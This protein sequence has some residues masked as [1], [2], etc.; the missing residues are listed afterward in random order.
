[1][2]DRKYT[3]QV[4]IDASQAQQQAA[5]L[6]ALFAKELGEVLGGTQGSSQS[7]GQQMAADLQKAAKPLEEI[8][9]EM[10]DLEKINA[11]APIEQLLSELGTLDRV[12]ADTRQRLED[13]FNPAFAGKTKKE[14][15]DFKDYV[16]RVRQVAGEEAAQTRLRTGRYLNQK[17]RYAE[18]PT[19]TLGPYLE[20]EK[21]YFN[22]Q[23]DA[24]S[25]KQQSLDAKLEGAK[26]EA[27]LAETEYQINKRQQEITQRQI[28]DLNERLGA[29]QGPVDLAVFEQMEMAEQQ[30]RELGAQEAQLL[31]DIAGANARIIDITQQQQTRI[32][33]E[34]DKAARR[35]GD[36]TAGANATTQNLRTEVTVT[37]ASAENIQAMAKGLEATV[38]LSERLEVTTANIAENRARE[39][40]ARAEAYNSMQT[41]RSVADERVKQAEK[42]LAATQA[43]GKAQVLQAEQAKSAQA[44]ITAT[45]KAESAERQN[46]S[47]AETAVIIGEQNRQT[48][49]AK[50]ELAEQTQAFKRENADRTAAM[51]QS[52]RTST[53]G[54]VGSALSMIGL[55]PQ[56]LIGGVAA[57]L[58]LYS[59][60]QV[61]RNI[62]DAGKSGAQFERQAATFE[63]V[64][65]RV[66]VSADAMIRSIQKA[67][68]DTIPA[69]EAMGFGAQILAQKWSSSSRDVVGDTGKLIEASR[70][71]SQIYTV[72]GKFQ[73][74]A[75]VFDRLIRYIR[76]GNKELVDQFGISNAEI[77][78]SLNI[79]TDG[80]ASA[81]GAADRFRGLI[82][83]LG[84]QME[85]TGGS[86]ITT[87]DT[88]EQSAKRITDAKQRIDVALAKP[89]A[90]IYEG[91]S[92]GVENIMAGTDF[93]ITRAVAERQAAEQPDLA[94][95]KELIETFKQ[96][97]EA[98]AK[99]GEATSEYKDAL[100]DLAFAI[101][102]SKDAT[103]EQIAALESMQRTFAVITEGQDAWT[104]AMGITTEE[105]LKENDAI[106]GI[107]RAMH[108]YQ[109]MYESG[110]LS[111]IQYTGLMNN[112]AAA[113][114]TVATNAGFAATAIAGVNAQTGG[115][116]PNSIT[117]T[118]A[119]GSAA[120]FMLR[121]QRDAETQDRI[122]AQTARDQAARAEAKR[123]ADAQQ[124]EYESAAKA[125]ASAFEQ[126]ARDTAGSFK[127]QLEK[128]PGLFSKSNVTEDDLTLAKY[129]M[130]EEN[131]DEYVRRLREEVRDNID[132]YPDVDI[133]DAAARIG[134][135]P[136]L[137]AEAILAKFEQKWYDSSLFAGGANLDLINESA[138]QRMLDEQ[139][140]SANGREAVLKYF[141]LDNPDTVLTDPAQKTAFAELIGLDDASAE[142][143]GA[144]AQTSFLKGFT[145]APAQAAAT[146]A[147][148][149]P[150]NFLTPI[151]ATMETN[152]NTGDA[153]DRIY[154]LGGSIVGKLYAGFSNAAT[155]LSWGQPILDSLAA[156]VAPQVYD[157][158]AGEL[159]Q[160]PQ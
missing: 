51:R 13:T 14:L 25:K 110:Q 62:F 37:K 77:A 64:A 16:E 63:Q 26:L 139:N 109:R 144:K 85:R 47:K 115:A 141:G 151:V 84:E 59:L 130:Y 131:P 44:A 138:V 46:I 126:A 92:F 57:S 97:D 80:L 9:R 15:A 22:R 89:I 39:E 90:N 33:A 35:A 140:A 116:N 76:E 58:G 95:R 157:M 136:N 21:D 117:Y 113:L 73:T 66:G 8:K 108:E 143:A 146:D 71:L 78:K 105:A 1:M 79:T 60:D 156:S 32:Q 31:E 10:A 132:K 48:I 69:T 150:V 7:A 4:E 106:F 153:A 88:Y 53:A 75:E 149:D 148:G 86:M 98:A 137:P 100:N 135:D 43:T 49:A 124:K 27:E 2:P 120:W 152:L 107:V 160:P 133:R 112:L 36:L 72:D 41:A 18:F 6:R 102:V 82:K 122:D 103:T 101:Y 99:N 121:Q 129:G 40:R 30:A 128:I 55:S 96:F 24:N 34:E 134:L 81:G 118:G 5:Q 145:S 125:A 29:N 68:N 12:L 19:D 154:G 45:A 127:D 20:D 147:N 3:Y 23:R 119:Q 93:G 28:A 155:N 94:G 142:A 42:E 67:S 38:A 104:R 54:G 123:L 111:L 91:I 56:M 74:T 87:A 17:D 61:G 70:R 50:K 52:A 83:L 11:G 158:L 65:R 159:D 114:Q